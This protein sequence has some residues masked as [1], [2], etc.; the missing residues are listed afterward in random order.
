METDLL[1]GFAILFKEILGRKGNFNVA[2]ADTRFSMNVFSTLGAVSPL[3]GNV[4]Q[5][6]CLQ[7]TV[8][9]LRSLRSAI[10]A[11]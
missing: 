3:A 5:W 6:S 11:G 4:V 2:V 10:Q 8:A 7:L 1:Y 9:G